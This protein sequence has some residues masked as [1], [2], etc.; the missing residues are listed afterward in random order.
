[1]ARRNSSIQHATDFPEPTGPRRP[2]T[3]AAEAKKSAATS[4]STA[5]LKVATLQPPGALDEIR[6]DAAD[7]GVGGVA[8]DRCRQLHRLEPLLDAGEALLQ[9]SYAR[10]QLLERGHQ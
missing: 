5:Y 2:R 9:R 10:L 8:L 4:P 3:K 7:G 1:M 6:V